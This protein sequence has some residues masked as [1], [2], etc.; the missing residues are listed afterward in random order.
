MLKILNK[1]TLKG[2]TISRLVFEFSNASKDRKK[3]Q[4]I[5]FSNSNIENIK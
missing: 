3:I 1:G 5:G 2:K 4:T